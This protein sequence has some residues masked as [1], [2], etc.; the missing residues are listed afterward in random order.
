MV[1]GKLLKKKNFGI[2]KTGHMYNR[3][4]VPLAGEGL[5]KVFGSFRASD[6]ILLIPMIITGQS[7]C[8]FMLCVCSSSKAERSQ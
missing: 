3:V 5:E 2:I 6:R 4:R 1:L 7:L 8:L